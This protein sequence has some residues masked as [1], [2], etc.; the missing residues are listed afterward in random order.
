MENNQTTFTVSIWRACFALLPGILFFSGFAYIMWQIVEAEKR[1]VLF[2]GFMSL[3]LI[4]PIIGLTFLLQG[5][6]GKPPVIVNEEHILLHYPLTKEK[7]KKI[8]WQRIESI[9]CERILGY[10]WS[11][12]EVALYVY[13]AD[14][15]YREYDEQH[16]YL[17][18]IKNGKDDEEALQAYLSAADAHKKQLTR[19]FLPNARI[20]KGGAKGVAQQLEAHLQAHRAKERTKARQKYD[21][22]F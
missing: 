18:E 6:F 3:L 11:R 14:A 20:L 10:S 2:Y 16:K 22:L 8:E 17:Q 7:E 12:Y 15:V 5:I 13:P 4:G 19:V 1:D 21:I 9:S